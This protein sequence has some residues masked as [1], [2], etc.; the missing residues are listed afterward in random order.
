MADTAFALQQTMVFPAL[1]VSQREL[2]TSQAAVASAVALFIQR[3]RAAAPRNA[4][5]GGL[6]QL[7]RTGG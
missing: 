6:K 2:H 3:A 4:G 7:R 1:P 5:D